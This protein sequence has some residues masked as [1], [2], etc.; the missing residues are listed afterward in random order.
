MDEKKEEASG[1][2]ISKMKTAESKKVEIKEAALPPV[3]EDA[4]LKDLSSDDITQVIVKKKRRLFDRSKNP[5]DYTVEELEIAKQQKIEEERLAR[6]KAADLATLAAM[7]LE[8]KEYYEHYRKFFSMGQPQE[9]RLKKFFE[10]YTMRVHS[11]G[12]LSL[13]NSM[14]R[15][16]SWMD[17]F[18]ISL[19]DKKSKP[20]SDAEFEAFAERCKNTGI[21][22]PFDVFAENAL[23]RTRLNRET[24]VADQHRRELYKQV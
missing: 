1:W 4:A 21:E 9:A 7:R 23:E 20:F 12:A 24:A 3:S 22:C 19:S 18:G 11:M 17:L 15:I 10:F 2:D 8:K 14:E 5:M 6:E 16:Q 13:K